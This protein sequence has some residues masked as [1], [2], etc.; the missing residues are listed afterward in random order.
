VQVGMRVL[1]V[2]DDEELVLD[3]ANAI[4]SVAGKPEVLIAH[5]RD[6]ALESLSQEF[7]DLVVLDL[8]IPA[9]DGHLGATTEHGLAVFTK[10]QQLAPGTPICILTGSPAENF[11]PDLLRR[12]HHVDI[13]GDGLKVGVVQ[14]LKKWDFK[15]FPGLIQSMAQAVQ[16]LANVELSRT[17]K[18]D[19]SVAEDRLVRIFTRRRSGVHCAL[20][21][22]GGL[23]GSKVLRMIIT[24]SDGGIRDRAVAKLGTLQEIEAEADRYD[25]H[26][27]RLEPVATPR[28][29]ET[30]QFGARDRAGVFYSLAEGYETSLFE[31][32][33][34][35]V[36]IVPAA[37]DGLAHLLAKWSDGVPWQPKSIGDVRRRLLSDKSAQRVI[38]TYGLDWAQ[39]FEALPIH[40]RWC[41]THG[42]LHGMNV[43]VNPAGAP[44]LIDYGDVAFGPPALD[45]VTLE[46]SAIFH[47]EGMFYSSEW[48]SIETAKTWGISRRTSVLAPTPTL[49]VAVG[50]GPAKWQLAHGKSPQQ[51]ILTC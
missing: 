33:R 26:I 27:T 25:R 2:E 32:V 16:Q 19:L 47:P 30:I 48:P 36:P 50:S 11:I 3:L 7:F 4:A 37:V 44:A 22:L 8:K 12:Q 43:L 1:V 39:D 9:A 17:N 18:V 10:A 34:Q 49:S 51:P 45:P 35:E 28:R 41:C 42:D 14:F 29:L 6:S 21:K 23:S 15:E 13:W 46:L 40:S 24:G 31:L 5:S 20:T 38:Q